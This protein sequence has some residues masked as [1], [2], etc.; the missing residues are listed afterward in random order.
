MVVKIN[1][2]NEDEKLSRF[3]S[4]FFLISGLNM[5]VKLI[6]NIPSS[7]WQYL[8]MLMA[9]LIFLT[10]I[11]AIPIL[12]KR[13]GDKLVISEFWSGILFLFSYIMGYANTS[14]LIT[15]FIWCE[16]IGLPLGFSAMAVDEPRV[17]LTT[18][19]KYSFVQSIPL[20]IALI[21]MRDIGDYSMSA[22]YSLLLPVTLQIYYFI[23]EKSK[24]DLAFALFGTFLIA[25]FG[26]RGPLISLAFF[27]IFVLFFVVERNT[28]TNI[29]SV[30]TVLVVTLINFFYNQFL[31]IIARLLVINGI[32]SYTLSKLINGTLTQSS[33]RAS[34]WQYY[35]SLIKEKPL[36]GWGIKGAWLDDGFGP[37]N[38]LIEFLLAFGVIFG[39]IL[40]IVS[41]ACLFRTFLIKKGEH[42]DLLAIFATY[43]FTMFFVMGNWTQKPQWFIFII[44]ALSYKKRQMYYFR[45][46]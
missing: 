33:S 34:L 16:F 4:S 36:L 26:A 11:S 37:H 38:T 29:L 24:I 42:K 44:L 14:S 19:H 41:I 7:I 39:G 28:F 12:F 43:C 2:A 6:F 21:R 31:A 46:K 5:S 20:W 17:L 32:R 25:V 22:S 15:A 8:S 27:V 40:C 3:V 23:K 13:E 18:L 30:L 10:G 1:S 35:W 9:G 45:E